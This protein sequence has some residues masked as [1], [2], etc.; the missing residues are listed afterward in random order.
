MLNNY[1]W[2]SVFPIGQSAGLFFFV[3]LLFHSLDTCARLLWTF[4]CPTVSRHK[5]M[6][7]QIP[8]TCDDAVANVQLSPDPLSAITMFEDHQAAV[9]FHL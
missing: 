8:N 1:K 2:N 6:S 5:R 3:L 7:I 4:G 9:T